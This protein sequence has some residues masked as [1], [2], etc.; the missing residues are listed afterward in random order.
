MGRLAVL[1]VTLALGVMVM[2]VTAQE[3]VV[4]P[5]VRIPAG[6]FQMGCVPADSACLEHEYPRHAVTISRPFDLM[7]TEVTVTQYAQFTRAT[8]Y[9]PPRRPDFPQQEDGP[10]VLVS[11]DDASAFCEWV[12]GRLPTEAEW[13]YAARAGQDA[14]IYGWGNELSRERAN[15]GTEECCSGAVAGDD[16]W[17]NTARGSTSRRRSVC[18]SDS[19]LRKPPRLAI[20]APGAHGTSHRFGWRSDTIAA[21]W[22]T[23]SFFISM[24]IFLN[25]SGSTTMCRRTELTR[26]YAGLVVCVLAATVVCVPTVAASLAQAHAAEP[27]RHL[28]GQA[29]ENPFA[30]SPDS[31]AIGRKRYVFMCRECHGNQGQGDGDMAHAG[32]VPSDF[33]D[34]VW[35]HGESDESSSSSSRTV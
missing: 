11:W 24:A 20:S 16:L 21:G 23:R 28:E 31:I 33:T 35:Q 5:W 9:L 30:A 29:L 34:D 1:L 26:A 7:A 2:A 8:G 15:F 19:C 22:H 18:P 27:H 14:T 6:S 32:R 12:G 13:E 3:R 4:L 10:I 17:F 25:T